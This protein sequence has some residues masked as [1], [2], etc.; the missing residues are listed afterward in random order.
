MTDRAR[1]WRRVLGA[2]ERSGLT[3]SAFCRREGIALS[4]FH[5]WKRRLATDGKASAR[6]GRPGQPE[7][8]FIEVRPPRSAVALV[9]L[10]A[11]IS[12]VYEV[13]LPG[14]R[15]IRVGERFDPEA[16]SRLIATVE[17]AC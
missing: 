8:S 9:D 4:T 15:S 1:H 16:L 7:E 2:W 17:A 12:P 10:V 14:G 6:V 5:W 13:V 3:Q 11:P